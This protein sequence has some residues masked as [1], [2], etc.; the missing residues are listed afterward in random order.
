MS[1]KVEEHAPLGRQ[2]DWQTAHSSEQAIVAPGLGATISVRFDPDAAKLIR[3]AA[4]RA[5]QTQSEFVHELPLRPRK[6]R[7]R[8]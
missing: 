4:K 5:N 1:D 2:K 6:R 7:P 8:R 3:Q